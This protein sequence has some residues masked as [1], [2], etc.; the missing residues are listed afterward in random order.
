MRARAER[1]GGDVRIESAPGRG[2][3]VTVEVPISETR[4]AET[5][6]R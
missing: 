4:L 5:A 6:Q 3:P 1:F 2:T